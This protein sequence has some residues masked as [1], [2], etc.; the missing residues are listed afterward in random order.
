MPILSVFFGITIRMWFDDH[1][2][3][4]IHVEY[5]GFEA[6]VEISSGNVRKGEL[7]RKVAAIVREWCLLHQTELLEN[8]ARAQAFAPLDRIQGADR[9]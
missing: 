1:P 4:H 5:Q 6:S 2:P 3:P 7:P 9:D 8:W